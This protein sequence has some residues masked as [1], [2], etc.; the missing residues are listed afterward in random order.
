[1]KD[2]RGERP[3]AA[4][5]A[6]RRGPST[7]H[8]VSAP[9]TQPHGPVRVPPALRAAVRLS[10]PVVGTG[11]LT[12]LGG[13]SAGDAAIA[14]LV[15][16]LGAFVPDA[17]MRRARLL[18][19]VRRLTLLL[20]PIVTTSL[21]LG[22]DLLGAIDL[23][24]AADALAAAVLA[25]AVLAAAVG[26]VGDRLA[27]RAA[28]GPRI[29]R[30]AVIG[31]GRTADSLHRELTLAGVREYEVVGRITTEPGPSTSHEV[32]VLGPLE[33]VPR[34]VEQHRI[35]LLLMTGE[36]PRMTVFE[37]VGRCLHLPVRLRELSSFYEETFGHVPVAEIN[38]AWF[39]YILHPNYRHEES[40]SMRALDIALALLAGVAALPIFLIL[41]VLIRRDGG[42][43]LFRQVRIG[44]SGRPFT[45]LKL[46]TMRPE[47]SSEWASADDARVTAIGR[48]LRRTH[49][50]ELPQIVNV[51]RGEMS[52][53]GPR[54]EQPGFVD[55]LEQVIP[56]YERR[57]LIKPGLTGWAQVRCGYAGSEVGSAWKVSHDLYY[58][59]HRSFTMNVIIVLET[60]R[61]LVADPQ[62]TAEP[63][64]VDFILAPVGLPAES[65]PASA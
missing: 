62:Y 11:L 4:P 58:I 40:P 64:S 12:A 43:V 39:Q 36:A 44:E 34:I 27:T 15:F 7:M 55:Q 25:S 35:D 8:V 41:A 16:L 14:F 3:M 18:P 21:L 2:V 29:T 5:P 13:L 42:P 31:S 9:D 52:I 20:A 61:T 51:L 59:K 38:A 57:H 46:R 33:S 17:D 54:P 1:M 32:P 50:D 37:E 10:G 49:L 30:V 65:A 22:F 19:L 45:I 48:L 63:S 26:W 6:A 47:A 24:A 28:G 23:D 53:V 60:L 56:F